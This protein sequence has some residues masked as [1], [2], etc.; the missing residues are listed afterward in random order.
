M[1][2]A[3]VRGSYLKTGTIL[4]PPY[5]SLDTTF[6]MGVEQPIS[7]MLEW[8]WKKGNKT[9]LIWKVIIQNRAKL[10]YK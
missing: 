10:I 8:I 5:F 4:D 9:N 3:T 7:Q 1:A 6:T 2:S